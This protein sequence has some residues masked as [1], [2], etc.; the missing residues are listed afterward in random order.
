LSRSFEE[1]AA[2]ERRTKTDLVKVAK[3]IGE[4]G[5]KINQVAKLSNQSKESVRY[6]YHKLIINKGIAI[7][8][9]PNYQRLGFARLIVFAKLAP[10]FENEA[11]K[12]FTEMSEFCYL[13]SFTRNI[14]SQEY[15]IHIVVPMQLKEESALLFRK[16]REVGLFTEVKVLEFAEVRN[17][18]MKAEYYDFGNESWEFEWPQRDL[19]HP[20]PF[21]VKHEE[22]EKYDRYDLLILKEL[23]KD[24]SRNLI[25]MADN[26]QVSFRVLQAHYLNHVAGRGL[27]RS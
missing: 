22:V 6:R 7:Q 14:L 27:V 3:Y 8:A 11:A 4:I 10:E 9:C 5:P 26:V 25:K 21:S 18:P 15:T 19:E 2:R 12:V 17:P 13:H 16:L 24:A 1:S 23:E 20:I